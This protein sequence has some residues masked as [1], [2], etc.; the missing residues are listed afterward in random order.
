MK[1]V[2]ADTVYY[3]GLLS[4]HDEYHGVCVEYTAGFAGRFVTSSWILTELANHLAA[5]RN[6]SIFGSLLHDLQTDDRV[7]IV[8]AT[9]DLFV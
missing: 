6:R 2:F 9:Q 3:L 5:T 8:P 1:V 4:P 7:E